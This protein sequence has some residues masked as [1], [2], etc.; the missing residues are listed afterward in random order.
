MAIPSYN[1]NWD[2][3]KKSDKDP[4]LRNL[5]MGW[6]SGRERVAVA[7][8]AGKPE[9]EVALPSFVIPSIFS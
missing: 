1:V 9:E 6:F 2:R 7:A 5:H 8:A 3:R 4:N